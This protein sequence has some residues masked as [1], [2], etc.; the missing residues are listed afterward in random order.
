M[1]VAIALAAVVAFAAVLVWL[2]RRRQLRDERAFLQR[3]WGLEISRARAFE[4]YREWRGRTPVSKGCD[5][6]DDQ[7]W[8]DLEMDRVYSRADRTMSTPGRL[9]LYHLLRAPTS[10]VA[11][12]QARD[13]TIEALASD[14][15][16]RDAVRLELSRLGRSSRSE[17]GLTE[18]LWGEAPDLGGNLVPSV[19]AGVALVSVW[20]AL[21]FSGI[22]VLAVAVVFA[23]NGYLHQRTRIR[24]Q[25]TIAALIELGALLGAG[26]RLAAARHRGLEAYTERLAAGSAATRPLV[27]PLARI[28]AGRAVDLV[29]EYI[30]ILLLLEVRAL[31]VALRRL[32][33][34]LAALRELFLAVGE[35]D[36]LQ[37]AGSFR[38]GLLSWCKPD[39]SPSGAFLEVKEAVH[40]L[41][42]RATPNSVGLHGRGCLVTGTNMAGKSTFLRTLGVNA[43][44]AQT[45]FTCTC[46]RYA[47][48]PLRVLSSMCVADSLAEGKSLYLAEAERL[49]AIIRSLDSGRPSLCLID[50]LLAG[51][52]ATDR[53]A[54]SSA[55]LAYL[56]ARD[57]L[58]VAA[59][60]DPELAEGLRDRLD[61]YHFDGAGGGASGTAHRLLPGITRER[62]AVSLL[63]GLGYPSE[64]LDR[65]KAPPR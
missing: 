56:A 39:L 25:E 2:H 34:H 45:L 12:L 9:V 47:A 54:A 65:L 44:L 52:N 43:V 24:H 59:T 17:S 18:L 14:R 4:A 32:R 35:L 21:H 28:S 33:Q 50:E 10:S 20:S 22:G 23:A 49:L 6:I 51:T 40:P 60:H 46:A 26:R 5:S 38:S 13:R 30:S 64:I 3:T 11:R 48:S 36:A 53:S 57:A 63:V 55:I 8:R 29:Y 62:N 31:R 1:A 37:S 58:V 15:V 27:F 19:L 16:T 41:L 42:E 7:T 61:G